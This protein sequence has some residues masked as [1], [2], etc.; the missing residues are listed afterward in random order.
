MSTRPCVSK[1]QKRGSRAH[2]RP[3][4]RVD[5]KLSQKLYELQFVSKRVRAFPNKV[6][7]TMMSVCAENSTPL[8]GDNPNNP[9]PKGTQC[10]YVKAIHLTMLQK[11]EMTSS[12]VFHFKAALAAP[13]PSVQQSHL[14][15]RCVCHTNSKQTSFYSFVITNK[16]L[17]GTSQRQY[18]CDKL[19]ST[20]VYFLPF[21]RSHCEQCTHQ[22]PSSEGTCA[23]YIGQLARSTSTQA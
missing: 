11:T 16:E 20:F 17:A 2:T 6:V 4:T 18:Q 9:S 5:V 8:A 3:R 12:D 15:V 14:Q 10:S 13:A 22:C 19:L 23:P 1:T 21:W 7:A